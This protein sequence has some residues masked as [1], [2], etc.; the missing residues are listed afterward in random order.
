[1]AAMIE[2][3]FLRDINTWALQG[4]LDYIKELNES[5]EKLSQ[6]IDSVVKA[7]QSNDTAARTAAQNLQG[8][9]A[10]GPAGQAV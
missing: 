9:L 5:I 1:M 10:S 4:S 2:P 7:Q 8:K 3:A 6:H